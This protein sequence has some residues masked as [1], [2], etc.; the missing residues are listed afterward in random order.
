M[1][2][3]STMTRFEFPRFPKGF[4]L[5]ASG[6]EVP[7][8]FAPV[9][10]CPNL[11]AHPWLDV[12]THSDDETFVAVLGLCVSTRTMKPLK[13][14][15]VLHSA[16]LNSEAEFI[17]KLSWLAGRYAIFFG[18]RGS[19][20]VVTDATGMRSVFYAD[21]GSTVA[22]HAFLVERSFGE[23]PVND[24]LPF[25]YGY[26]GNRTPYPRTKILTPNT[27]LDVSSAS[28][29]RFWPTSAPA[30]RSVEDVAEESLEAATTALRNASMGRI[31]KMALTAGLDS[32]VILAV[33]LRS[34]IDLETYTYGT[35]DVT[36]VDRSLASELAAAFGLRHSVVPQPDRPEELSASLSEVSYASHHK[37]LLPGLMDWFPSPRAIAMSGNLLEIGR[38]F[39]AHMRDSG[40]SAPTDPASMTELHYRG[41]SNAAKQRI[42][43]YGEDSW[44]EAA[45][46]AFT[47]FMADTD[48]GSASDAVDPFDLFYWEHRMG[49]WHGPAMTERDFYG[50]SL[51][52]FNS[53]RTFEAMLGVDRDQRDSA[54]VFYTMIELVDPALLDLPINPKK[55]PQ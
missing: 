43:K 1:G 45:R 4:I 34:R 5:T 33:A 14:A 19:V 32:R 53:R 2:Y 55:W 15:Q 52:P 12:D 18:R 42:A 10:G 30:P 31:V 54:A 7:A 48:F 28:V 27:Y 20:R 37:R 36:A 46:S 47:G 8:A 29:H 50:E 17:E 9:D 26:P 49:T 22:S 39:Y 35:T 44:R 25:Q 16:L 21:D 3:P 51:I 24:R 38:S 6:S 13:T 41:M 40:V 11:Y 23:P